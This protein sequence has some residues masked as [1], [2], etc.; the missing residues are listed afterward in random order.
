MVPAVEAQS[1]STPN[2]RGPRA[3]LISSQD[4]STMNGPGIA[5]SYHQ[6]V[7]QHRLVP[8]ASSPVLEAKG[9]LRC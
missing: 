4:V 2:P 9:Q 6:R 1:L 5:R 7:L 8:Q 3:L